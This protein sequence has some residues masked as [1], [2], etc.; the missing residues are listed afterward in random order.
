MVSL[1]VTFDLALGQH[2]QIA[3]AS[4]ECSSCQELGQEVSLL[5]LTWR[6]TYIDVLFC[7]LVP[8][9]LILRAKVLRAPLQ[10]CTCIRGHEYK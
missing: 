8:H 1:L 6:E 7:V 3:S 9:E 5:L 2:N 4:N 10:A